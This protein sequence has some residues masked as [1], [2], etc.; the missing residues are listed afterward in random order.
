MN[1]LTV[2]ISVALVILSMQLRYYQLKVLKN[3]YLV[4]FHSLFLKYSWFWRRVAVLF[5]SLYREELRIAGE[6]KI[7]LI[8]KT[9]FMLWLTFHIGGTFISSLWHNEVYCATI[10]CPVIINFCS[11]L[12]FNNVA[13]KNISYSSL[14]SHYHY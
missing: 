1:F 2:L 8:L 11:T 9:H 14:G 13:I 5:L 3:L 10:I 6:I 4:K 7:F 12:S